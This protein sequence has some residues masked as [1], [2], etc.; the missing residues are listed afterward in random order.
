MMYADLTISPSGRFVAASSSDA[1]VVVWAVG[2]LRRVAE[3][4]TVLDPM[5]RRLAVDDLDGRPVVAAASWDRRTVVAYDASDSSVLW[6]KDPP[7]RVQR[8]DAAGGARIAVTYERGPLQIFD[9]NTGHLIAEVRGGQGLWAAGLDSIAAVALGAR[10]G[11]LD[12]NTWST[13]WTA[14]VD[15]FAVLAAH[16]SGGS[17]L[18]SDVID[19]S[20]PG[21]AH[22]RCYSAAGESLWL[23]ECAR[24]VNFPWL[25]HSDPTEQWLGVEHVID[26]ETGATLVRWDPDGRIVGRTPIPRALDYLFVPNRRFLIASDGRAMDTDSGETVGWL[27]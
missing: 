24:E 13:I 27:E 22:V 9:T 7:K 19:L 26:G 23:H 11:A 25:G 5:G 17:L 2:G 3:L 15:G 1:D 14:R 4:A 12:T 20:G 8:I 18:V 10:L 6:R 16:W 21:N